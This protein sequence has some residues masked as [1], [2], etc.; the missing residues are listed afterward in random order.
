MKEYT[1]GFFWILNFISGKFGA[2]A[3]F[4]VVYLYTAELYPTVIRNTAIGT[5]S[6]I[7]KLGGIAAPL[8]AGL[9]GMAPLIIMGGSSLLGG[10]C[11]TLLPETLG[12]KLP[13]SISEVKIEFFRSAVTNYEI[14]FL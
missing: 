13:E 10:I 1:I 7:S 3:S 5:A 12:A 11:A 2:S 8:L 9:N 14:V 6:M 4:A